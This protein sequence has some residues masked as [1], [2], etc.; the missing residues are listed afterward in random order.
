MTFQEKINAVL[1]VCPGRESSGWRSVKKN[2]SK[3]VGGVFNSTHLVDLARDIVLKN[4]RRDKRLFISL[5]RKRLKLV[6]IDEG[7]HFHVHEPNP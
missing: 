7:D 5:C 3:S 2:K 1:R 6:C 4:K